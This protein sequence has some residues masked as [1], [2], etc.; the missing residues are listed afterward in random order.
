MVL[1]SHLCLLVHLVAGR[2]LSQTFT[3][4]ICQVGQRT[5]L[6][7]CESG[8]G[9]LLGVSVQV[10]AAMFCFEAGAGAHRHHDS[11]HISYYLWATDT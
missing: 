6:W 1:C 2:F 4:D 5:W 11:A 9:L 8:T 3:L 10:S 7:C